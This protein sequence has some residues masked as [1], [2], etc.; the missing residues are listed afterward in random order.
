VALA[1]D[2]GPKMEICRLFIVRS[3][4][5]DTSDPI[6]GSSLQV[7]SSPNPTPQ[8]RHIVADKASDTSDATRA[9]WPLAHNP[10]GA[11]AGCRLPETLLEKEGDMS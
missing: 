6:A 7:E 8:S 4:S 1:V 3:V 11:A 2:V 9:S 10:G 5:P